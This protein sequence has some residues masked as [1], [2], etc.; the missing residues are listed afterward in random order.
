MGAL[1]SAALLVSATVL[2]TWSFLR[3]GSGPDRAKVAVLSTAGCTQDQLTT[4]AKSSRN[5][6]GCG[7]DVHLVG[8]TC[9]KP[10]LVNNVVIHVT[11]S[12][13]PSVSSMLSVMESLDYDAVWWTNIDI[14]FESCYPITRPL[15][16]RPEVHIYER[17]D[18]GGL[19]KGGGIDGFLV[20]DPQHPIIREPYPPFLRSG[21]IWDNWL[22]MEMQSLRVVKVKTH[23][24][25]LHSDHVSRAKIGDY[26]SYWSTPEAQ[27]SPLNIR[28]RCAGRLFQRGYSGGYGTVSPWQPDRV[29]FGAHP[30]PF[31]VLDCVLPD[32]RKIQYPPTVL[33]TASSAGLLSQFFRWHCNVIRI[34]ISPADI[35]VVAFDIKTLETLQA[36][37]IN[38][39]PWVRT[40]LFPHGKA[41]Y[42]AATFSAMTH[43][44]TRAIQHVLRKGSSVLWS[45]SDVYFLRPLTLQSFT[46][47]LDP[48]DTNDLLIS[49][50][51][52]SS[53][54]PPRLNTGLML[55][56]STAW[57]I[58][59]IDDIIQAIDKYPTLTQQFLFEKILC[60]TRKAGECTYKT[61][62]IRV[63]NSEEFMSGFEFT[64]IST[65]AITFHN[66]WLERHHQKQTR[67]LNQGLSEW[68]ARRGICTRVLV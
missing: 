33:M 67:E 54:N 23:P 38:S 42:R 39:I 47:A 15:L 55:I 10:A 11:P 21:P 37:G 58:D 29:F 63:L 26:K 48:S 62:K 53:A 25:L 3:V 43:E 4:A 61:H 50:N 45:D 19:H 64:N 49:S 57:T 44:K 59:A 14:E 65:R 31:K 2:A 66:N 7:F 12:K 35:W 1:R 22:V 51:R 30:P 27:T 9:L 36:H 6:L 32:L 5:W 41:E 34:G 60:R 18:T 16:I 13:V 52:N 46:H 68:D 56:K 20:F 8:Q 40:G 28:N 17:F 24:R